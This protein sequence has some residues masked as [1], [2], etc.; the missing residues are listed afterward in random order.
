MAPIKT[1]SSSTMS[2]WRRARRFDSIGAVIYSS[3]AS[4]RYLSGYML[5]FPRELLFRI[6]SR[7]TII[8]V[9]AGRRCTEFYRAMKKGHPALLR[10]PFYFV[11]LRSRA[12]LTLFVPFPLAVDRSGDNGQIPER[13]R[14][15][16][17]K[18]PGNYLLFFPA[19]ETHGC[20]R[21]H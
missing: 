11:P 6:L 4:A 17:D 3:G 19:P 20:H 13:T 2:T 15:R 7:P 14:G 5:L 12:C 8:I 9:R 10:S 21:E 16:A 18:C 1:P